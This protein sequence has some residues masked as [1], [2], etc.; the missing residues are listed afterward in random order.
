MSTRQVIERYF[1]EVWGAGDMAAQSKLIAPS[2]TGSW[3]IAGMPL[4]Q[5]SA[6]HAAWVAQVRAG[7]P[8]ARYTVHDLIVEG[9]RAVAR[10]TL[11]GTHLGPV[12]GRAPTGA[13]TSTEQ[14]F[15]FHLTGGQIC[16]EWVS[17]DRESFLKQLAPIAEAVSG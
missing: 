3:L 15:V 7:L 8:D 10:V 11:A 6:G 16:A 17:F 14:I 13:A 4:R 12:A 5:G 1:A 9:D 2:Y